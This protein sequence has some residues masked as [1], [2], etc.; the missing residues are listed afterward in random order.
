MGETGLPEVFRIDQLVSM[1]EWPLG[2]SATYDAIR[3]GDVPSVR[4][5]RRILVPRAALE[6]LLTG[7]EREALSNA[8]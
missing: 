1:P 2:R 7:E 3:R 6:R 4:I 8:S 5:G